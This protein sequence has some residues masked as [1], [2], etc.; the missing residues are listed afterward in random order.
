[1][2]DD[3]IMAQ[4]RRYHRVLPVC[5]DNPNHGCFYMVKSPGN[6]S[7]HYCIRCMDCTPED[8]TQGFLVSPS[9]G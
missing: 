4:I 6:N 1:M 2:T 7:D 5:P 8:I 3:E 9:K